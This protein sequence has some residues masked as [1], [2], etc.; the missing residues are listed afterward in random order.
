MLQYSATAFDVDP[1]LDEARPSA[2]T[3][4][5][6]LSDKV[7]ERVVDPG[8]RALASM[9][10]LL[11]RRA[12]ADHPETVEAANQAS[13]KNTRTLERYAE[14]EARWSRLMAES[15]QGNDGSYR[16]LLSELGGVVEAYLRVNFGGIDFLEDCVQECLM[17]IHQGRHTYDV[18]RPFRPWLFTIIRHRAI[19]LLRKRSRSPDTTSVDDGQSNIR[20][21]QFSGEDQADEHTLHDEI[22]GGLSPSFRE[23]LVLTKVVGL[24]MR[25][26]ADKANISEAAM[27]VRV[28]RAIGALKK[29]LSVAS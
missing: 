23:A 16:E 4:V 18:N 1:S 9:A 26:A 7:L 13:A 27:K 19:D 28:H 2:L 5:Q 14:D 21:E 24:S 11:K 22:F 17:A 15:Q 20:F 8:N 6:A 10:D 12:D 3:S 29:Q 25:E